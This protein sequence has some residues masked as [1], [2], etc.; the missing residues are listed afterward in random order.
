MQQY[1]DGIYTGMLLSGTLNAHLEEIDRAAEDLF[2]QL[3]DQMA[4]S[5]GVTEQ[6]KAKNQMQWV[7]CMNNIREM[8]IEIVYHD[9]INT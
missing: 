7:E 9:L 8:A 4:A 1:H 5:E 6:L 3:V 2:F